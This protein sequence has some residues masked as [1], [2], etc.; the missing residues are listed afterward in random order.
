MA[1]SLQSVDDVAKWLEKEDLGQFIPQFRSEGIVGNELLSLDTFDLNDMHIRDHS[2]QELILRSIARLKTSAD[3][4]SHSARNDDCTLPDCIL[5]RPRPSGYTIGGSSSSNSQEVRSADYDSAAIAPQGSPSSRA[6]E[7]YEETLHAAPDKEAPSSST[8]ASHGA[9]VDSAPRVGSVTGM[10]QAP[11]IARN[12]FGQKEMTDVRS[13]DM[14]GDDRRNS[15]KTAF[16]VCDFPGCDKPTFNGRPGYCS[17][18]HRDEHQHSTH[19]TSHTMS[20]SGCYSFLSGRQQEKRR[21]YN[22]ENLRAHRQAVGAHGNSEQQSM[23]TWQW[24]TGGG[25]QDYSGVACAKLEETWKKR[26]QACVISTPCGQ[27]KVSFKTW[28]QCNISGIG[29]ERQVRRLRFA[30]SADRLRV[31]L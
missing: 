6:S 31:R 14:F 26:Y 30:R 5:Q 22:G 19:A 4:T 25:W 12:S 20:I 7:T 13:D 9:R 10:N 8:H 11:P 27:F 15:P 17:K 23:G 16:R 2:D 24:K 3:L 1:S 29:R 21:N 18:T 28:T